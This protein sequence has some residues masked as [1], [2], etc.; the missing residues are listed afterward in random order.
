MFAEVISRFPVD[1]EDVFAGK[2]NATERA[3]SAHRSLLASRPPCAKTM[4]LTESSTGTK[5]TSRRVPVLHVKCDISSSL[6]RTQQDCCD[7]GLG[8]AESTF[9]KGEFDDFDFI[10][11]QTFFSAKGITGSV[12][13]PAQAG[14]AVLRPRRLTT[15]LHSGCIND[16]TPR[17][18]EQTKDRSFTTSGKVCTELSPNK[19]H[20]GQIRS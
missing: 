6:G 15:G 4:T 2:G 13:R 12:K 16:S 9:Q 11:V 3:S 1:V 14:G 20:K 8:E 18:Q 19:T 7:L 10:D 5:T 17:G